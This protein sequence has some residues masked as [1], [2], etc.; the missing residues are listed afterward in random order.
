MRV[1]IIV[2][3]DCPLPAAV[4]AANTDSNTH[5]TDC[6][7]GVGDDIIVLPAGATTT[8]SATLNV[9]D[10]LTINGN[11]HI[12]SGNDAMRVMSATANLALN[13]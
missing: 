5:D 3:A 8:L 6:E 7:A 1:D 2:D 13:M 4:I 11:G 9:A 12:I 10:N